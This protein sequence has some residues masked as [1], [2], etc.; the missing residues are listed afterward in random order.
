ME[1]DRQARLEALY[2]EVLDLGDRARGWFDGPGVAW[3]AG[4][5]ADAQAA[6]AVES[7]GTTARLLGA[8]GWLLDLAQGRGASPALSIDSADDD[9]PPTSPLV[10]TAGG[11]VARATRNL[12]ARIR[13]M[14]GGDGFAEDSQ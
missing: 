10:G 12:L 14:A 11:E 2:C 8:M 6:V 7:L 4:L 9:L 1:E 3:R 13:R 5:A